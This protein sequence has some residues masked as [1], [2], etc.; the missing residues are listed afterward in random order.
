MDDVEQL[1]GELL[2]IGHQ[3]TEHH[4]HDFFFIP[5]LIT[6]TMSINNY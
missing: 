6:T 2:V 1:L 4:L 5:A 3:L